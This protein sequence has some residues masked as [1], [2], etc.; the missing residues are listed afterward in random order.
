VI[1]SN[2][3]MRR[4]FEQ[5]LQLPPGGQAIEHYHPRCSGKGTLHC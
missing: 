5:D 2:D 1:Q 3:A 4:G